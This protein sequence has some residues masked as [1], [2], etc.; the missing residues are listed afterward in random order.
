[1]LSVLSLTNSH[2]WASQEGNWHASKNVGWS[3]KNAGQVKGK[4]QY[5]RLC[6]QDF[7]IY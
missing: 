5:V 6:F 3:R 7:P 1:M 2:T 4:F